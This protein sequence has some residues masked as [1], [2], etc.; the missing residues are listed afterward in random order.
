MVDFDNL[1]IDFTSI[2]L[3]EC[4]EKEHMEN[5]QRDLLRTKSQLADYEREV[6]GV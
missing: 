3:F 2:L 5:E 6:R 1:N 4:S